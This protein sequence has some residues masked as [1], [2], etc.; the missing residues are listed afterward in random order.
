MFGGPSLLL[1]PIGNTVT[2]FDSSW[3]GCVFS[4]TK[5]Y[6]SHDFCLGLETARFQRNLH[7]QTDSCASENVGEVQSVRKTSSWCGKSWHVSLVVNRKKLGVFYRCSFT[8]L[9]C[10]HTDIFVCCERRAEV[11]IRVSDQ[12]PKGFISRCPWSRTG[13][14]RSS[15]PNI[16]NTK[17]DSFLCSAS[18][19]RVIQ[20]FSFFF[21]LCSFFVRLLTVLWDILRVRNDFFNINFWRLTFFFRILFLTLTLRNTF[22]VVC[23]WM[24]WI[25][26]FRASMDVCVIRVILDTWVSASCLLL[27]FRVVPVSLMISAFVRRVGC[28]HPK[29]RRK[30]LI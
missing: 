3:A 2:F 15:T 23:L 8:I 28:P 19:L 9:F 21:V 1:L 5:R 29:M 13:F 7:F 16:S 10:R 6:Y 26:C 25:S 17:L 11:A 18:W 27:L 14:V 12:S 24:P 20:G 4:H 30:P 22:R